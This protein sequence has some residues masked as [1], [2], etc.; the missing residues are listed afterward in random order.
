MYAEYT[1]SPRLSFFETRAGGLLNQ[2]DGCTAH[3]SY[4]LSKNDASRGK[5]GS[6]PNRLSSTRP[7]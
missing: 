3:G 1:V 7:K 2:F 5:S 6:K 4:T